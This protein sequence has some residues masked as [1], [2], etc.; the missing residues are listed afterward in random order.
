MLTA[1]ISLFLSVASAEELS[2]IAPGTYIEEWKTMATFAINMLAGVCIVGKFFFDMLFKKQ[3]K[4]DEGHAELLQAFN[5]FKVDV[6][7]DIVSL[8]EQMKHGMRPP[9]DPALIAKDVE[10]RLQHKVELW[11]M[12][13]LR[14]LK[15]A[16]G[17]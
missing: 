3:D 13:H 17:K 4:A 15:R 8:Q 5:D 11:V 9:P 1:I 14:T 6:K 16:E 12:K 2:K 7:A 10:D